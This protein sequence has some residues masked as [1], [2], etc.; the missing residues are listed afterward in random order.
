[1]DAEAE[2]DIAGEVA[3]EQVALAE[4][5]QVLDI[6]TVLDRG[7]E[8]ATGSLARCDVQAVGLATVVA[9]RGG[10]GH[11]RGVQ[12]VQEVVEEAAL[13]DRRA[14][15]GDAFVADGG[16]TIAEVQ[17][18]IVHNR[19]AGV[20]D[21]R[22]ELV[23][24]RRFAL[25]DG[26]AADAQF[27]GAQQQAENLRRDEYRHRAGRGWHDR[28]PMVQILE[29]R[30]A[31]AGGVEPLVQVAPA[32]AEAAEEHVRAIGSLEACCQIPVRF[33]VTV[34]HS[35]GGQQG[36]AADAALA[37][38]LDEEVAVLCLDRVADALAHVDE[39]FERQGGRTRRVQL[40][41]CQGRRRWVVLEVHS[42]ACSGEFDGAID[43]LVEVGR[44]VERRAASPTRQQH[45][46]LDGAAAAGGGGLE[47]GVVELAAGLLILRAEDA[48]RGGPL[49]SGPREGLLERCHGVTVRAVLHG[50]LLTGRRRLHCGLAGGVNRTSRAGA[51]GRPCRSRRRA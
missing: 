31:D 23:A 16:G 12:V 7:D 18:R 51:S 28:S 24:Q 47:A 42:A 46:D 45:L 19:Q 43:H 36:D 15:R 8:F 6:E 2:G 21:L 22:A 14:A 4:A 44:I 35:A 41:V 1:M 9:G 34:T 40:D 20:E 5:D 26:A 13:H 48:G 10:A 32:A 50:D 11:R 17:V 29:D 33:L 30:A 3:V 37:A 39:G 49:G 38:R 27:D 25:G